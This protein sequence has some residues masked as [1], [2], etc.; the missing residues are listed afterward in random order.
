MSRAP[1][2]AGQWLVALRP[3]QWVK[4][5]LVFAAPLAAGD[6]LQPEV[7]AASLIAFVSFVLASSATYLVNDVMDAD[8]DRAHPEKARRPVAA[9]TI[10]PRS[11]IVVAALLAV[12]SLAC[13]FVANAALV[14]VVGAYLLVSLAY[15]L[16]LKHEPVVEL[17]LLSAGFLLR[18][19]AGGV[20]AQIYLSPWFLLV[21]GFGSLGV[22]AGKRYGELTSQETSSGPDPAGARPTRPSLAGY[23]PS[24]LRFVW[25]LSAAVTVTTYCLWAVEVGQPSATLPWTLISVVPFA[26]AVMRYGV[27][28]DAGRT[29]APEE[30]VLHDRVLLLLGF[31]W[32]LLFGAGALAL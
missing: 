4:N 30:V 3:R 17:A 18:A 20:A 9:G 27:D 10:A 8:R 12:I 2:R 1:S 13:A 6:I 11:A 24:Y 22:A 25:T 23:T 15:S 21:A 32:L 5:L 29:Q 7:L 26:L 31:T 28:L 19:I 14:A 16:R